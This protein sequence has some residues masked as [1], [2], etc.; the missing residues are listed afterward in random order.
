MYEV[1]GLIM[2]IVIGICSL[3]V[4]WLLWAVAAGGARLEREHRAR[5]EKQNN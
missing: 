2:W 3:A 4:I 1:L 5:L